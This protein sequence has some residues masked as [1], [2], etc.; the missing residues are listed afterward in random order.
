V[1]SSPPTPHY[2]PFD[3]N[4]KDE[5]QDSRIALSNSSIIAGSSVPAVEVSPNH[6][7]HQAILYLQEKQR[8]QQQQNQASAAV[9]QIEAAGGL[10]EVLPTHTT[11]Q[12]VML[13]QNTTK[14]RGRIAK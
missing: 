4:N 5:R 1:K 11:L 9:S 3:R 13:L 14:I 8:Q 10:S 2:K 7:A 6:T 12:E